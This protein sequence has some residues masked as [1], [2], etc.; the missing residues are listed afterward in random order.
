[1]L[2]LFIA[3]S[4]AM[5]VL[6]MTGNWNVQDGAIFEGMSSLQWEDNIK[7]NLRESGGKM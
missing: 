6:L 5:F 7:V 3:P 4:A 1:M 2:V